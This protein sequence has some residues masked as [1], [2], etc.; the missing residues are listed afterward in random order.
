MEP[1]FPKSGE[2]S[3]SPGVPDASAIS[4][5]RRFASSDRL[6]LRPLRPHDDRARARRLR[7]GPASLCPTSTVPRSALQPGPADAHGLGIGIARFRR[8]TTLSCHTLGEAYMTCQTM[9][10]PD[11]FRAFIRTAAGGG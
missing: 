6:G 9:G 1:I 3:S 10:E 8:R 2:S 5:L 4:T 11:P 7:A